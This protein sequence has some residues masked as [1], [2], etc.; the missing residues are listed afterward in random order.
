MQAT[1]STTPA[2]DSEQTASLSSTM[3]RCA[4]IVS[5]GAPLALKSKPLPKP[6]SGGAI[7]KT[8]Y[9]GVCHSDLHLLA[10]FIDLGDGE[11]IDYTA[12]LGKLP[13][14]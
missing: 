14:R 5:P 2:L 8:S 4:E 9:A 7:V 13:L 11:K 12:I 3:M 6:P 1:L 10:G